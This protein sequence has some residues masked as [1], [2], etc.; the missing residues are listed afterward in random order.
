MRSQ[1]REAA[2]EFRLAV[3]ATAHAQQEDLRAAANRILQT[4]ESLF[5]SW[6][7]CVA[8][9]RHAGPAKAGYAKV[10][11][12]FANLARVKACPEIALPGYCL[13]AACPFVRAS[14]NWGCGCG[15]VRFCA[16]N[17]GLF[18]CGTIET[19]CDFKSRPVAS[20]Y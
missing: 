7:T 15:I 10:P 1:H 12:T 11:A 16:G 2:A 6:R 3:W 19:V 8:L 4:L 13:A 9:S 18:G 20:V 17:A 5:R 14:F